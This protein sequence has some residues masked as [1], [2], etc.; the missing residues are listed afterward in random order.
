MIT[1]LQRIVD[2]F[3]CWVQT[4]V[5]LALNFVLAA[6]GLL[7]E[8]LL[9][10]CPPMPTLPSVPSQMIEGAGWVA[11]FFPVHQLVLILVFV[12]SAQVIWWGVSIGLRWAKG[13]E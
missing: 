8:G 11:W 6:L 7:I 10:L 5:V 3:V 2:T 13:V 4:G 12:I 1:L 9:L